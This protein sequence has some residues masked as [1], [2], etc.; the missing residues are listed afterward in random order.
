MRIVFSKS[1]WEMW[2]DPM[3]AF[4]QRTA[5]DGFTATEIYLKSV[6]EAPTEIGLFRAFGESST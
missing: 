4:V 1:K 3:D 5:E 6:P 2:D